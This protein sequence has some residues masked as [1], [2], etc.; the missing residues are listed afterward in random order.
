[1]CVL[2]YLLGSRSIVY[3]TV[4]T[5]FSA[6]L[7]ARVHGIGP[8]YILENTHCRQGDINTYSTISVS[9]NLSIQH[10]IKGEL[11]DLHLTLR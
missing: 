7:F 11:Q 8:E 9:Q 5:V 3:L 10:Q 4:Y 1:M 6:P 2:V